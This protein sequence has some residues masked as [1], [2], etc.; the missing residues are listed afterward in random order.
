MIEQY[1]ILHKV[2][3]QPS[4]DIAEKAVIGDEQGWVLCTCGHRCYPYRVISKM[5]S[6]PLLSDSFEDWPE[7]YPQKAEPKHSIDMSWF[8]S[9]VNFKR[10]M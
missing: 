3:G 1:L 2:R 10:R 5:D 8:S 6:E 9:L 7:H 4:Y